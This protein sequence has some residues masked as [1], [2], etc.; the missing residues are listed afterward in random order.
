MIRTPAKLTEESPEKTAKQAKAGAASEAAPTGSVRRMTG[1]FEQGTSTAPFDPSPKI[2]KAKTVPPKKI[3][4]KTVTK[5]KDPTESLKMTVFKDRLSEAEAYRAKTQSL[6]KD[7]GNTRGDL[8]VMVKAALERMYELLR[9][10]EAERGVPASLSASAQTEKK[11]EQKTEARK[12]ELPAAATLPVQGAQIQKMLEEHAARIKENSE[13]MRMLKEALDAHKEVITSKT[14]ASVAAARTL[15]QSPQ[16]KTLHSVVVTSKDETESGEEVLNRIRTAVNAT[17]GEICIEK[18]RKAKDRKVIIGCGTEEERRK[19]RE[20]LNKAPE[21]HVEEIKNKNPLVIMKNVLHSNSDQDILKALKNQN[22]TIFSD[23]KGDDDKIEIAFKK[24]TRNPHTSH[25][26]CRVSTKI[27]QRMTGAETVRI[28]LQRVRVEDQS[29]LVQCSLCLG[30]GHG[31]RFCTNTIEKCSHCGG[32]HMR[33]D[34]V[35]WLARAPPSC[36]NCVQAKLEKV[37]HNAFSTECQIRK[38]WDALARTAV[39]YC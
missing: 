38:K 17:D 30:Y 11:T 25:V 37:D 14:Y 2:V 39:A 23:L 15:G 24:R 27:W 13:E 8:V 32:P 6:L 26:V 16:Q 20:K 29:P 4:N 31:R 22:K 35:D 3:L 33:T 9:E 1:E 28:D 19:V 10:A 12:E 21:L 5:Y 18:I 7:S 36:C 34:C